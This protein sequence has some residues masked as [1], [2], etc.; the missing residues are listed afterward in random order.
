MMGLLVQYGCQ[1]H[2]GGGSGDSPFYVKRLESQEKA[3]LY[4]CNEL[5]LLRNFTT[6]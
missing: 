3:A 2:I 1:L 6:I 4:K 5:L